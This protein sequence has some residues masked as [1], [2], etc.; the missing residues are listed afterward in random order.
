MDELRNYQLVFIYPGEDGSD[1]FDLRILPSKDQHR[2]GDTALVV[3]VQGFRELGRCLSALGVNAVQRSTGFEVAGIPVLQAV[4]ASVAEIISALE[5]KRLEAF[6]VP[7]LIALE[8]DRAEMARRL[9]EWRAQ[10]S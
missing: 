3:H 1:A 2:D 6:S 4:P 9:D 5:R 8:T 7:T 10:A